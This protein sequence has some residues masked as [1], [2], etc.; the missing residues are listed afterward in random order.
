MVINDAY[1]NDFTKHNFYRTESQKIYCVGNKFF[2]H[3]FLSTL[4]N[5]KRI[6]ILPSYYTMWK[7]WGRAWKKGF[8]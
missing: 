5:K 4:V 3:H 6:S 2:P 7:S 1:F 8:F